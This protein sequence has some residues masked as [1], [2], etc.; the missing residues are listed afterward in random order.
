MYKVLFSLCLIFSNISAKDKYLDAESLEL[1]NIA[2]NALQNSKIINIQDG[3]I[4][5]ID[6]KVIDI[7]GVSLGI[8]KVL[9]DLNAKVTKTEIKIEMSGDVL[10][11]FDKATIR[12]K[13]EPTLKNVIEVIQKY[14][15]K[16]VLIEGHTDS[17]GSNA[18]NLKLSKKRS[19]SV[20]NW[21]VTNSTISPNMILAKGWGETRPIAKNRNKDGSDKPKG[22]E[23]NRRVEITVK[24]K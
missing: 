11:D 3:K 22:R 20:K 21:L 17:K 18:Y 6:G 15:A 24:I 5:D 16:N 2:Q 10:F 14:S 19:N 12:K 7:V 9:K 8:E 4:I 23:K 13:A 1:E